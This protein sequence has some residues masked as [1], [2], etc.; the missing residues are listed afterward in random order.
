MIAGEIAS[1]TPIRHRVL[2]RLDELDRPARSR[3]FS[4]IIPKL[5]NFST[6]IRVLMKQGYVSRTGR[7]RATRY[8]ITE[9]GKQRAKLPENWERRRR[10][11]RVVR[12]DALRTKHGITGNAIDDAADHNRGWYDSMMHRIR[13]GAEATAHLVSQIEGALEKL[14]IDVTQAR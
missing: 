11:D 3:D 12:L 13:N 14:G 10:L 8:H 6:A 5:N 2:R 1:M 7:A 4:D 9:A